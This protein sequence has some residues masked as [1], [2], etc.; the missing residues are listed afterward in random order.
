MNKI[1]AGLHEAIGYARGVASKAERAPDVTVNLPGEP[2]GK[3]R[4]RSRIVTKRDGHQF[5]GV[6]TD[7][8]TRSYEGMLRFAGQ[9]AMQE[10]SLFARAIKVRIIAT[11]SV[12]R[13]WSNKRTREALGGL[14]RPTGRPDLDNLMKTIDALNGVVWEDDSIIVE[15]TIAKQYGEFPSLQVEVWDC[16]GALL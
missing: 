9:R 10:R 2:K 11:F 3:G 8:E 15:A 13:S 16:V 5:V 1:A 12:P 4:P 14:V 7:A 6:Y